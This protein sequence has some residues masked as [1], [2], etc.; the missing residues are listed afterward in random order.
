RAQLVI[1]QWSAG[2]SKKQQPRTAFI[3]SRINTLYARYND[4]VI[5]SSDLLTGLSLVVGAKKKR[6]ETQFTAEE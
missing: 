4:G 5:N 1:I 3:Q 6:I 2:A